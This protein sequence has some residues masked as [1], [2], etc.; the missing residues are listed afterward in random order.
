MTTR[1][2]YIKAIDGSVGQAGK[3]AVVSND[4]VDTHIGSRLRSLRMQRNLSLQSVG[5]ELG[6]TYQQIRKYESGD[7][8]ISASTLYRLAEFFRVSPS[9]FFDG[10]ASS[11]EEAAGDPAMRA[12][13]ERIPDLEVRR[14]MEGLLRALEQRS[15]ARVVRLSNDG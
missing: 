2:S 13:L 7:N 10:L 1:P 15:A 6:L 3:D 12:V 4:H 5:V 11:G 14:H 9:Y 8:R